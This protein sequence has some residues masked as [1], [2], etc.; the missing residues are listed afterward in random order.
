[1][2]SGFTSSYNIIAS[3]QILILTQKTNKT[4][5]ENFHLDERSKSIIPEQVLNYIIN[6]KKIYNSRKEKTGKVAV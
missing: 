4:C 1:M 5:L 6:N 3:T 2:M